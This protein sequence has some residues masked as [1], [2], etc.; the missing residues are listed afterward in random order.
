MQGQMNLLVKDC[1]QAS[2]SKDRDPEAQLK[3]AIID[4]GV[5]MRI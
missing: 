5:S 2:P 3:L 1:T 4:K